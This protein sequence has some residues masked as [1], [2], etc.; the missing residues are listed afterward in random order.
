MRGPL[1][2]PRNVL[3]TGAARGIGY[4]T[5]RLLAAAG[6]RVMAVSRNRARLDALAAAV[7]SEN[8]AGEVFPHAFDLANDDFAALASAVAERLPRID[9]L[10]NNAGILV[11]K[12]FEDTTERDLIETYRVNVFAPFRLIQSLLPLLGGTESKSHVVNIGSMGG[13][14]GSSKFPGLSAYSS[15]KGAL[16]VLT[17][18]LAEE[19]KDRNIIVNC[20]CLGAVQ[21]EMLAAAFPGYVAPLSAR[22]MAAFVADFALTGHQFFNGK[23]LPVSLSTP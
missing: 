23:V 11:R 17:E 1:V 3:V 10:V 16:A 18:C 4:E 2:E 8:A 5:V 20:L 9:A 7:G 19:L 15:S 13:A 22:Q 6:H 21:T 14:Q 12:P